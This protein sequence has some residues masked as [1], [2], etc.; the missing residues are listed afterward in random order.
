MERH[1]AI[2][3]LS[4][5]PSE[6]LMPDYLIERQLDDFAENIDPEMDKVYELIKQ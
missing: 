3:D 4:I 2:S 1:I 5:N 6:P